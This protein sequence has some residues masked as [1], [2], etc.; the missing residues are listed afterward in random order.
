MPS[1]KNQTPNIN[2]PPNV[3]TALQEKRSRRRRTRF[4]VSNT[5][6]GD[7]WLPWLV[8]WGVLAS[9]FDELNLMLSGLPNTP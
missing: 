7:L 5:L 8:A 1:D 6:R 9:S 3:G 4:T 2:L